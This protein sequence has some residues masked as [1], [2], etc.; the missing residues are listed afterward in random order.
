MIKKSNNCKLRIFSI[1]LSALLCACI[2][3]SSLP[4]TADAAM[5]TGKPKFVG[6]IWYDGSVPSKFGDYWN[7]LTPENATKWGS[8]EPQQG[9]YNFSQAK[10]MY[11]YC[12]TNKIPFK[13]TLIQFDGHKESLY[14]KNMEGFKWLREKS[15]IKHSRNRPLKK[16]WQVKQQQT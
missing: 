15:L 16:Y 3:N 6:N 11:N 10:A 5:A 12:K 8:C 4:L 9:V 2:I 1:L 7:Q 14:N 13:L